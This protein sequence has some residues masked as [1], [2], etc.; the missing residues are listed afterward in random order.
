VTRVHSDCMLAERLAG[1]I[2]IGEARDE[3]LVA[4]RAHLAGCSRCLHV[5]GG[6][7]DIERVMNTVARAR[8]DER[9]E[10]ERRTTL[11]THRIRRNTW[12]LASALAAAV[13]L[14]IGLPAEKS[15]PATPA[16]GSASLRVSRAIAALDT[17]T[18][19]RREG[20]A[21]SLSVDAATTF[22]TAFDVSVDQRGTP[23]RCT[24]RKSS[25]LHTLDL[26]VCRAAMRVH[27]SP[28]TPR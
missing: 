10:P 16:Q 28:P 2:A 1:A 8:D 7:R 25:G 18:A 22:S 11:A 26:S 23:L 24:I 20:R 15:R 12:A 6:E 3:E 17:Q 14:A 19:P 21:E 27:Y 4:Y 5:L 13:L 9:W